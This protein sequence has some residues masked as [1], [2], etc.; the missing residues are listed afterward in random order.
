MNASYNPCEVTYAV[1]DAIL[2]AALNSFRNIGL[3][4]LRRLRGKWQ[5]RQSRD[6]KNKKN[7]ASGLI[8]NC[9][10]GQHLF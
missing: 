2:F 10:I 6:D 8:H 7:R 9:P 1:A 3:A 4:L 5:A